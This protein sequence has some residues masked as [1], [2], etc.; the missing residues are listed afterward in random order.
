MKASRALPLILVC[1]LLIWAVSALALDRG[2]VGRTRDDGLYFVGALSLARGDGYRLP[3]RPGDPAAAKY[4]IGFPLALAAAIRLVGSPADLP[5][6]IFAARLLVVV[7]GAGF[8]LLSYLALRRFRVPAPWAFICVMLISIHPLTWVMSDLILSDFL[9]SSLVLTIILLV[10][11]RTNQDRQNPWRFF[12]A[13]LLMA[14]AYYVRFMGVVLLPAIVLEM[15]L[16]RRRGNLGLAAFLVGVAAAGIPLHLAAKVASGVPTDSA[17]YAHELAAVAENLNL[18]ITLVLGNLRDLGLI[19]PEMLVPVLTTQF[20][21][22]LLGGWH[23]L[24]LP[25]LLADVALL[26]GALRLIRDTWR[27]FVGIWAIGAFTLAIV[28]VWPWPAQMR[29]LLAFFPFA[30]VVF[31][32]GIREMCGWISAHGRTGMRVALSLIAMLALLADIGIYHRVVREVSKYRGTLAGA[33]PTRRE[34]ELVRQYVPRDGVVVD[35]FPEL[36]YLYTSRQAAPLIED[37]D[38]LTGRYGDLSG[39]PNWL[40]RAPGRD[41]YIVAVGQHLD[42]IVGGI[43]RRGRLVRTIAQGPDYTVGIVRPDDK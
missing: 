5:S 8:L 17:S 26:V 9:Y 28:T 21:D 3:S 32:V 7:C 35:E 42:P 2:Y 41:L 24:L 25:Y 19:F 11:G 4:P 34:I 16:P 31:L 1:Y 38:I 29:L 43:L 15:T 40:R 37:K 6:Q 18:W 36:I 10:F 30:F 33:N 39:L 12:L 13:G 27:R 23:L 22:R 20:A 14:S